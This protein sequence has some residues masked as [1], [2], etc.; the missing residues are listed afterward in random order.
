MQDYPKQACKE[1][2]LTPLTVVEILYK[3]AEVDHN[4]AHLL[5]LCSTV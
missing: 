4:I 1:G 5:F 3:R 2:Q